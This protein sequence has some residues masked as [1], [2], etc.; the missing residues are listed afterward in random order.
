MKHVLSARLSYNRGNLLL[1][2]RRGCVGVERRLIRVMCRMRL[3]DMVSTDILQDRVGVVVK[4]KDMIIQNRL[5]W[6][7]RV[8]Y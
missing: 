3:V 5:R 2:M 1:R 7:G 4:I 6:Y 8:I